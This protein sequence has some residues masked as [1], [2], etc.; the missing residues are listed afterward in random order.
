MILYKRNAQGKP[1]FWTIKDDNKQV[2]VQYGLVGTNGHTELLDKKLIKVNEVE[3]RIKAKRKEGYK[4]LKELHDN[5]PE[6]LNGID[7]MSYLNTY[8]PKYNTTS[9]GFVLPMLC[10]TL[11]DNK[12]FTKGNYFGQWKI[13]GLR[14]II[15]AIKISS[16]MFNP[17]RL[18]YTS[19]EGIS[20]NLPWMDE[21]ILP[22]LSKQLVEMMIEEGVCLDGELYIPAHTVNELNSF[23]KNTS[24]PQHKQLQFWC[25]DICIDN[26]SAIERSILRKQNIKR[27]V[28]SFGNAQEHFNCK[29]QFIVLPDTRVAN[30][31]DAI[32]VRDNF[33]S[34]GFEGLVIRNY[35]SEYQY[36]KRNQA[37]MKFKK[38]HDGKFTIVDIVPEGVRTN[39]PKFI[40]KNDINSECFEC[41]INA[42]HN[43][44][45][46]VLKNKSWYIGRQ[47]FV[48]YRERSGIKQVPFHAKIIKLL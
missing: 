15:G 4:E 32:R 35:T 14:C 5:A 11:K 44:Q 19:R 33:I 6:N 8:L 34:L 29:D 38:I 21:I 30:F 16:D 3:S 37:M 42:P 27:H 39:L 41:T 45:E 13:N 43:E 26:M 36:D 9:E 31:D 23:V 22:S 47:A 40:L 7:L 17:I 10:K 12:P 28:Y 20:W 25:Y 48:E 1:I 18:T 46:L 24:L 2:I